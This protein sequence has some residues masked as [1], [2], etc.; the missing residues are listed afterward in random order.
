MT[1]KWIIFSLKIDHLISQIILR[2][3]GT[4]LDMGQPFDLEGVPA[5]GGFQ[6]EARASFGCPRWGNCYLGE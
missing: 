3:N 5:V 1:R 2:Y 6:P 4:N